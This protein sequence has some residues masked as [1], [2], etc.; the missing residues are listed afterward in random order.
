MKKIK[1]SGT[2]KFPAV[3]QPED[4]GRG[5]SPSLFEAVGAGL[6]GGFLDEAH[7]NGPVARSRSL[8]IHTDE[9]ALGSAGEE[10]GH[11]GASSGATEKHC[12]RAFCADA[13]VGE[14][15]ED[16]TVAHK[17]CEFVGRG[18]FC[19]EV[20]AAAGSS[21]FDD[22]VNERVAQGAIVGADLRLCAGEKSGV[23]EEFPVAHVR[24]DPDDALGSCGI[25]DELGI[26][27]GDVREDL[28]VGE[29]G[30]AEGGEHVGSKALKNI[31]GELSEFLLGFLF[32]I[33]GAE[34]SQDDLSHAWK[35]P[36]TDASEEFAQAKYGGEAEK[37]QGFLDR[38]KDEVFDTMGEE[39]AGRFCHELREP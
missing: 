14:D 23:G 8:A 36:I 6:G 37:A 1:W 39:N 27:E 26:D 25:S 38:S 19:K 32:A 20:E 30:N 34:V 9:C 21:A 24:N 12:R 22:F 2:L 33:G 17:L 16:A 5:I 10:G 31:G 29:K 11:G 4:V 7:V 3:L 35:K 18:F 28:L 15:A 13:L